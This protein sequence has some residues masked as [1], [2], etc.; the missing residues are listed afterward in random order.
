MS[1][2]KKQAKPVIEELGRSKPEEVLAR[3][4]GLIKDTEVRD[5]FKRLYPEVGV[6]FARGAYKGMRKGLKQGYDDIWMDEIIRYAETRAGVRI[7]SITGTRLELARRILKDLMMTETIEQGMGVEQIARMF[8][9]RFIE[10]FGKYDLWQARR[11]A[12]T[13]VL[14]ASNFGSHIGANE[15]GAQVK[16]WL[17]SGIVNKDIRHVGYPGLHNQERR[18]DEYYNVGGYRAMYPGD[19]ILPPEEVINCKCIEYYKIL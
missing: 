7:V 19:T 2:L 13:E 6:H 3:L 8:Q 14:T 1:S 4:D 15:A 10:E 5:S 17:T 18:M 11:I 12:Q 16:V 9:R